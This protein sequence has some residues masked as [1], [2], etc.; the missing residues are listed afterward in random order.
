MYQLLLSFLLITF[1]IKYKV[2][3]MVDTTFSGVNSPTSKLSSNTARGATMTIQNCGRCNRY[4][5]A[6]MTSLC[7]QH[8]IQLGTVGLI[9]IRYPN[10]LFVVI[11]VCH[12]TWKC[13]LQKV[14]VVSVNWTNPAMLS[15]ASSS[16]TCLKSACRFFCIP[17]I[18]SCNLAICYIISQ[19]RISCQIVCQS[20]SK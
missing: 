16:D 8:S 9:T 3:R 2:A 10:L 4:L 13:S 15:L 17:S 19:R 1:P 7:L 20:L 5:S 14:I 18:F 12:G 11:C 6:F